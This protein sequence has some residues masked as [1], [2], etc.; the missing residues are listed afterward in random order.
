[1]SVIYDDR[2]FRVIFETRKEKDSRER[3]SGVDVDVGTYGRKT[4]VECL[5]GR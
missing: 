4:S 1:M 5:T 2:E 3:S